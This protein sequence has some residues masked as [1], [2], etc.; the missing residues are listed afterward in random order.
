MFV[1]KLSFL[2]IAEP[3]CTWKMNFLISLKG[4]REKEKFSL[5]EHGNLKVEIL[6][7][8]RKEVI[9]FRNIPLLWLQQ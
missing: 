7:N 9:F 6:D 8:R 4:T 5:F 3:T 1:V 2:F